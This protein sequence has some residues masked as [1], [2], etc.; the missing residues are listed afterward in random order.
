LK[1]TP[2]QHLKVVLYQ[3]KVYGFLLQV[4]LALPILLKKKFFV[5]S[6]SISLSFPKLSP[7]LNHPESHHYDPKQ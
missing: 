5:S 7:F 2:K 1:K 6:S 4:P 3:N